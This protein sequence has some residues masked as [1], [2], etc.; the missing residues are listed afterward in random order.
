MEQLRPILKYYGG[1]WN[2][3]PWIL[4]FFPPHENYVE[5]CGGS[6]SVLLQ[7]DPS[8]LEVYN[9]L[10]SA[11]VNFFRVLREHPQAFYEAIKLTPYAR[12]EWELCKERN[13][14]PLEFARR[15]FVGCWM[16]ISCMPFEKSQGWRSA[17]NSRQI[18]KVTFRNTQDVIPLIAQRLQYVQIEHSDFAYIF[19]RYDHEETLFY[20]DPPY[21]QETRTCKKRYL[22]EFTEEQ[23]QTA[24]N[25]LHNIKGMAI[26]S[27]YHCEL[28][29]DLYSDWE[30]HNKESQ[31]NGGRK[32]TESLYLSPKVSAWY[33]GHKR[34]MTIFDIPHL[35]H[36]SR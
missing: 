23:H 35:H 10:D 3:A 32:E 11:V 20:F 26:V 25:M 30:R 22:Q 8:P 12:E 2:L 28:Y 27:G 19:T 5:P 1:K 13:D 6:A 31:C 4:S 36:D 24:A 14:N 33:H 16:S 9:D 34:Q 21:V 18:S 17:S 29:D 7:K 15:F